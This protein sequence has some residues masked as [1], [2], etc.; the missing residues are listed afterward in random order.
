[1]N[2]VRFFREQNN[3]TQS[4][5]ADK[6]GLSLRTVQRI[7][8]GNSPKGFTIRV[9]AESLKITPG[10]LLDTEKAAKDLS[11]AKVINLS[12]LAFFI[13]P[14]GNILF[15][16]ILIRRTRDAEVKSLGKDILGIQIGWTVITSVLMMISP[17]LQKLISTKVPLFIVLLIVLICINVYIIFRNGFELN[18]KSEL[19]TKLRF[20]LL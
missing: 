4:E 13:L 20:S 14:F 11:E 10:M 12:C 16:A 5:L 3:L 9:L 8:A 1:M 2:K 19:Y 6:A 15:P 18:N 17:F 7:E